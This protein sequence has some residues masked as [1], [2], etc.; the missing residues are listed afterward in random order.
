MV[1]HASTVR[2]NSIRY[3]PVSAHGIAACTDTSRWLSAPLQ[4]ASSALSLSRNQHSIYPSDFPDRQALLT[5]GP[6]AFVFFNSLNDSV[7][8]SNSQRPFVALHAGAY[9]LDF[10]DVDGTFVTAF[11]QVPVRSRTAGDSE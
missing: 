11:A 2:F 8:D 3:T 1:I 4:P 7:T 10:S 6:V 9:S 5:A